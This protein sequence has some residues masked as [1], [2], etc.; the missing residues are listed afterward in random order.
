M[1]ETCRLRSL[2]RNQKNGLLLNVSFLTYLVHLRG[3]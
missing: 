2:T 3:T 1:K